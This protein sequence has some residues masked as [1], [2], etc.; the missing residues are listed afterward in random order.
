MNPRDVFEE[1][2]RTTEALLT[3]YRLLE[4]DEGPWTEHTLLNSTRAL[5][6]C[7]EHEALI[8]LQNTF[9]VGIVRERA[10]M[11]IGDFNRERLDLLLR[12]AV[13]AACTA[14]DVFVPYLLETYLPTVTRVRQRNVIPTS[15][16]ARNFFKD[17]RL[18]LSDVWPI[19]EAEESAQRWD[20][21]AQRMLTYCRD[22]TLSNT[23]G[24]AVTLELL[25][26]E[27]PWPTL[28][29]RAGA[30]AGHS[31]EERIKLVIARRND[32]THRADRPSRDPQGPVTPISLG[33][34]DNH[35]GAIKTVAL[36]A[37]DLV[38]DSLRQMGTQAQEV[39]RH[40]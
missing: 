13:T 15:P 27:E 20:L 7:G 29:R 28:E 26:V 25:G 30:G 9:F 1:H 11:Q 12:Q 6:D 8:L 34:T 3:V 37:F 4:Q 36:E 2:Y 38:R 24:I 16:L 35:V 31:L 33:W 40:G 14:L 23:A 39:D 19:A 32:I 21:I 5:L 18:G 10:R 17:F 22:K